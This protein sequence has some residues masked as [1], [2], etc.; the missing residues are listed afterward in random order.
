MSGWLSWFFGWSESVSAPESNLT[1]DTSTTEPSTRT[2]STTEDPTYQPSPNAPFGGPLLPEPEWRV[3]A[4]QCASNESPANDLDPRFDNLQQLFWTRFVREP[5]PG[6]EVVHGFTLLL[7]SYR[8]Q[9]LDK[10]PDVADQVESL[11]AKL[12]EIAPV[13]LSSL[14]LN[15]WHN[16]YRMNY[17]YAVQSI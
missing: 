13:K 11:R 14:S 12:R 7:S 15:A 17:G 8:P 2:E 1:V 5:I 6:V 4:M 10:H 3:V 16:S 9:D